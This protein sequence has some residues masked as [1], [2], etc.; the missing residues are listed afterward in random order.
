LTRVGFSRVDR[1]GEQMARE[2]AIIIDHE[3]R[4]PAVA[5]LTVSGVEL[6]RDQSHARIFITPAADSDGR[7]TLRGLKRA[8]P[9]LRKRLGE[10]MRLR[11]VPNLQF[12]HDQTLDNANRIDE[13]LAASRRPEQEQ[14]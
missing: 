3:V 5:R 11:T 4:D 8:T 1:L 2:L 9:F 6:A 13:L 12:V 14:D 10:Q 7:E